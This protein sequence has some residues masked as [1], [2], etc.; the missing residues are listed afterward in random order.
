MKEYKRKDKFDREKGYRR[1]GGKDSAKSVMFKAICSSCGKECDV[2]FKPTGSKPVYCSSCFT[3]YHNEGP[4][5][6]GSGSDGRKF[7][8]RGL[9]E[10]D[11]RKDSG[12]EHYKNE[13]AAIHIKLDKIL[14]ALTSAA[15]RIKP[16]S[17]EVAAED[18]AATKKAKKAAASEPVVKKPV[19]AKKKAATKTSHE[20]DD[21]ED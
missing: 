4:R 12:V 19:K 17:A 9:G 7:S 13:L 5:R 1:N 10:I 14:A 16:L 2:P 3:T 20:E 11:H 18:Q 8:G 15:E 6:S 21:L